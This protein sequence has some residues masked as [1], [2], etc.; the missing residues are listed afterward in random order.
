MLTLKMLLTLDLRVL[1]W[2]TIAILLILWILGLV[3]RIARR[4][5]H[6]FLLVATLL[7]LYTIFLNR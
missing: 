7:T 2:A 5:I 6:I 1:L 3:F 4:F